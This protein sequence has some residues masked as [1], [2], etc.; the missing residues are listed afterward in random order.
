M[1]T[2]RRYVTEDVKRRVTGQ[3]TQ[4]QER[5]K[6]ESKAKSMSDTKKAA[7]QGKRWAKGKDKVTGNAK[8]IRRRT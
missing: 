7:A 2:A 8:A 3:P 5:E 6:A 1:G 4:R